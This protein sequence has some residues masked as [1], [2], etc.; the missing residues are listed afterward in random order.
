MDL[1]S[2]IALSMTPGI[3]NAT[4]RRLEELLPGEDPFAMS[5]SQLRELFGTHINIINSILGKSLHARAEEELSFCERNRIKALY[6]THPQY[7]KLLNSPET[8]DCPALLYVIGDAD[9]NAQ[10]PVAVVGTRRATAIGRDNTAALVRGLKAYD[11]PI[12]SGLA[13]GIDTAAHTAAL[14]YGLPTIAVLGHGLDR[15]Y[16]PSNRPLAKRIIE[17][18]GA[19]VTEYPSNT[20]INPRYFPARNRIIAALSEA[21]VV[22]EA[23]EKGG[24]LITAAIAASYH[25]EVYAVPGRLSDPYSKGTNNLIATSRALL[26]R[27]ANDIAFHQGW[28]MIGQQLDLAVVK[29]PLSLSKEEQSMIDLLSHNDSPALDEIATR[30]NMTLPQAASLLFNLEMQNLVRTLPGHLY[31]LRVKNEELR[32]KN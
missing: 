15:I 21:T 14:D 19:L 28:P 27:N 26:L 30:L 23:S 20:A 6:F 25:R 5:Q 7:P 10:R 24:A 4:L 12:V 9:L 22:V 16:P 17:C 3:G 18:G 1:L 32:M 13:Y 11:S 29:E 8:A 2:Q 31:Q